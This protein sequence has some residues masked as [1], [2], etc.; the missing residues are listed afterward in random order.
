MFLSPL[1][2]E[3]KGKKVHSREAIS[4][5]RKQPKGHGSTSKRGV[6]AQIVTIDTLPVRLSSSESFLV[7]RLIRK[8]LR[9]EK[10]EKTVLGRGENEQHKITSP[11]R[12]DLEIL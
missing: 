11:T 6:G 5:G 8:F 2:G 10:R 1:I 3:R 9:K 4:N 7:L 12:P